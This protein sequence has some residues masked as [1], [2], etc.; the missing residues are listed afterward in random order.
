MDTQKQLNVPL[1]AMR[2]HRPELYKR[3]L[4]CVVG[5]GNYA[6]AQALR[7]VGAE[8]GKQVLYVASNFTAPL[9]FLRELEGLVA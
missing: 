7:E 4:V 6:E 3:A 5:G 9:E 8:S 2:R 1:Q